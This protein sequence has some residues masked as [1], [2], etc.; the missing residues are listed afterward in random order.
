MVDL[1][2]CSPNPGEAGAWCSHNRVIRPMLWMVIES[3]DL[4]TTGVLMA[5]IGTVDRWLTSWF[6]MTGSNESLSNDG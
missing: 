4:S 3:Q 1:K 5:R 2:W 6:I